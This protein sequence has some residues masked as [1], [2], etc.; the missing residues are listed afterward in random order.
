MF[1]ILVPEEHP[2]VLLHVEAR[3]AVMAEDRASR[4]TLKQERDPVAL[5]LRRVALR[6]LPV[7][8]VVLPLRDGKDDERMRGV[9]ILPGARD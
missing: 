6:G 1:L 9:G 5:E 3:L 2:G 7:W 8:K 4:R